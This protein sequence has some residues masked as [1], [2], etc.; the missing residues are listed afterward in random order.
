MDINNSVLPHLFSRLWE[1]GVSG[2][3]LYMLK[4]NVTLKCM[5]ATVHVCKSSRWQP[6]SNYHLWDF[7][8]CYLHNLQLESC[9]CFLLFF[10]YDMFNRWNLK[11]IFIVMVKMFGSQVRD[12]L[13]DNTHCALL[14]QCQF[15][16]HYNMKYRSSWFQG[17]CTTDKHRMWYSSW[18]SK[19]S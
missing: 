14:A 16:W 19:L 7:P 6:S 2:H 12:V 8:M 18:V 4:I 3:Q 15:I 13:I 11:K 5:L 9:Q 1:R 10:P 17:Y